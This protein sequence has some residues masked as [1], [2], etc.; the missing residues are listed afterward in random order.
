VSNLRNAQLLQQMQAHPLKSSL[1]KALDI[2]ETFSGDCQFLTLD[3]NLSDAGRQNARSAKLRAAIRDLRDARAPV[4]ELQKKVEQKRKAVEMPAFDPSDICGFLKRQE[5]RAT[6]RTMD[7]G[8]R[9]LVIAN[10]ASFADALLETSPIVS[11]LLPAEKFIV[12]QA[13]ENR[14]ASLFG[15]ELAEIDALEQTLAEARSIADIA[16]NDLQNS[17]GMEWQVFNEFVKP[18]ESKANAPWLKRDKDF[19]GNERIIVIDLANPEGPVGKLATPD[20]IRD[21]VFFKDFAEYQAA[22]AA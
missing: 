6:L 20:Q 5:L 18:V 9:A 19:D 7:T 8:Q 16:R 13:R 21:G 15:R 4:D 3:K 17:S 22:R 2:A 11:G 1:A 14:L 10:D 12:D